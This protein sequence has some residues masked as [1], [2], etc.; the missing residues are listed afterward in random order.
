MPNGEELLQG[1]K[2]VVGALVHVVWVSAVGACVAE[3]GAHGV[4]NVD[5]GGIPVPRVRVQLGRGFARVLVL[6]R[7]DRAVLLEQAEEE[8]APGPPCKRKRI[9]NRTEN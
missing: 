4:V 5:D 7:V 9:L 6:V 3:A 8:V 1:D 2:Q